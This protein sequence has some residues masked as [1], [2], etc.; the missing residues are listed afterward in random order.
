[1]ALPAGDYADST[2]AGQPVGVVTHS[3]TGSPILP[4]SDY[5]SEQQYQSK[6]KLDSVKDKAS[7]T[8]TQDPGFWSNLWRSGKEAVQDQGTAVS[9]LASRFSSATGGMG[10]TTQEDSFSSQ[11]QGVV[12]GQSPGATVQ[13]S[14]QN[15]TA[16]QAA[17][18]QVEQQRAAGPQ[19]SGFLGKAGALVGSAAP[20]LAEAA[21]VPGSGVTGAALQGAVGGAL[22]PTT[23]KQPGVAGNVGTGAAGGAAFGLAGKLLGSAGFT[24]M[25]SDRANALVDYL[26]AQGVP[27]D[28]AQRTGSKFAG[29]LKNMVQDSPFT[30]KLDE[31][32]QAAFTANVM[33]RMGG[34]ET[35]ATPDALGRESLRISNAK[36][37]LMANQPPVALDPQFLTDLS[38]VNTTN[39][40]N[41]ST[42]TLIDNK[43]NDI[44]DA[45]T[46]VPNQP[47]LN[48]QQLQNAK[49][50]LD[51]WVLGTDPVLKDAGSRIQT[52]LDNLLE[53]QS[54]QDTLPQIQELNRQTRVL[55][56]AAKAA[57]PEGDIPPNKFWSAAGPNGRGW[58]TAKTDLTGDQD[59]AELQRAGAAILGKN[60]PQSGT[61]PRYMAQHAGGSIAGAAL[62]GVA[63]Y[64]AGGK[65]GAMTGAWGAGLGGAF[66]SA[67]AGRA[68]QALIEPNMARF[69]SRA[70]TVSSA[71]RKVMQN[72]GAKIGGAAGASSVANGPFVP[73]GINTPSPTADDAND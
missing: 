34:Q 43:I 36:N 16:S 5:A 31:D 14:G 44:F 66:G 63:G 72:T 8:T 32:Q 52:A 55:M 69:L 30:H 62:G 38:R 57:T 56:T 23:T 68:A 29:T 70:A 1:M 20:N 53:R 27:M 6:A 37:A 10:A 71:T 65:D 41:R 48:M 59:T 12:P 21:L 40:P 64:E 15:L 50:D 7:G 19:P 49:M 26:D 73:G 3:V 39:I 9:Q 24:N 51:N 67:V 18:Q 11:G 46:R 25:L 22:T 58:R 47:Q 13:Q 61:I 33:Q 54:N 35:L 17:Q 42:A 28:L 60:T 45:G 2:T 4:A